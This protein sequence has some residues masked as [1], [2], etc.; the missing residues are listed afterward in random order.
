[1]ENQH[2]S[3]DNIESLNWMAHVRMRPNLYFQNCFD[4]KSISS[5]PLEACCHALDEFIDGHCSKIEITISSNYFI[6]KYDAGMSL[7]MHFDKTFAETIMTCLGACSGNKKHLQVGDEFCR[8]GIATINAASTEC[9][10]ITVSNGQ[11]GVFDFKNGETVSRSFEISTEK[12]NTTLYFKPDNT[13]FNN[14][15]LISDD[16]KIKIT[17]LKNKFP[18]LDIIC[19]EI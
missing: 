2:Y 1:M 14:L 11:K 18:G 6:V 8:L 10:L 13:I 5:L 12:E 16:I 7:E 19:S 3:A 4:D 9:R 15:Q 17:E